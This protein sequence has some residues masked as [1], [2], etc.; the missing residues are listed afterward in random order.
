MALKKKQKEIRI[1]QQKRVKGVGEE[2]KITNEDNP[3]CG[4]INKKKKV[5]VCKWNQQRFMNAGGCDSSGAV[6]GVMCLSVG[7]IGCAHR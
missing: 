1:R 7:G 6:E 4:L 5:F 3:F 2:R